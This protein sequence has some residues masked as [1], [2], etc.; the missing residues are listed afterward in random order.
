LG[1]TNF[2]IGMGMGMLLLVVGKRAAVRWNRRRMVREMKG[3]LED[4]FLTK[5]DWQIEYEKKVGTR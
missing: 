5:S 2:L 1:I 4:Q 3:F